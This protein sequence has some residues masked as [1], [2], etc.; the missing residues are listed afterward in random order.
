[1]YGLYLCLKGVTETGA[2]AD[3]WVDNLAVV[4]R[5]TK[6]WTNRVPLPKDSPAIWA[7][8]K[9]WG[10]QAKERGTVL[11]WCPS[12]GKA[13]KWEPPHPFLV[14]EIRAINQTADD[15]ATAVI[16]EEKKNLK[17]FEDE[18]RDIDRWTAETAARLHLGLMRLKAR[19]GFDKI[20]IPRDLPGF[21]MVARG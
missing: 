13:T 16:E 11:R 15:E 6:L 20:S 14:G 12:H 3:I 8:V 21:D 17:G 2:Q 10:L 9:T 4:R 19:A 7:R 1:M 18:E 5:A